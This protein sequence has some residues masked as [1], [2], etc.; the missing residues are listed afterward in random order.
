[1]IID[2]VIAEVQD[3]IISKYV[4]DIGISINRIAIKT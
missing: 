4:N 2:S 3:G 1:M